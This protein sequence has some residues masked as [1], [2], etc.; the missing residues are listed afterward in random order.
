[1]RFLLYLLR[2]QLSSP[3]LALCIY[4]LPFSVTVKTILANLVG[5]IIFFWV[6]RYIFK[7]RIFF[8]LWE[9]REEITCA[10]CGKKAKGYR[11]VKTNNYDRTEDQCPE[12]RCEE[13]SQKKL[14][15]LKKKGI[16]V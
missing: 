8:P 7:S 16:E 11:L 10:D 2:W 1:M 14:I 3:I 5:G 15:Q 6:D 4:L 12:F 13:C 9:I